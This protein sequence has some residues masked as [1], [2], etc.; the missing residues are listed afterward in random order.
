MD[1]KYL[2]IRKKHYKPYYYCT[3]ENIKQ[4]IE[5]QDCYY[6]D[7]KEYKQYKGFSNKKKAR[8]I[9]TS[10]SDKVKKEV[11]ERDN[12]K[13]IFCQMTVPIDNANAHLIKRSQGGLGVPMNVFTAC[14]RCHYE[15]D[16]GLECLRYE[17]FAE[18][19]LKEYY[20]DKWDRNKLI[21]NKWK[22]EK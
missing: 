2:R 19:Y 10:I 3:N 9:A 4:I 15:E 22:E 20:G 5:K 12:H 7:Y 1:C 21:Y 18:Q 13:C 17:K 8:T 11:W 6:C 14:D 16:F